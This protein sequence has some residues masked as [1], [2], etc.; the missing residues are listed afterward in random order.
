MSRLK[1]P[2]VHGALCRKYSDPEYA[3]F[4]E[5]HDK[6]GAHNTSADAIAMGLWKSR[7]QDLHGFEIKDFRSD[8]L[9]ELKNPAKAER[10][11]SYCDYW[12]L[13]TSTDQVAKLDEIPSKWGLMVLKGRNLH[14]V[15]AAP[16]LEAQPMSR[17]FLAALLRRGH[18]DVMSDD[19]VRAAIDKAREEGEKRAIDNNQ[20]E[21]R[22]ATRERD[23]YKRA[24]E[25]FEQASG[26]KIDRYDGAYL[27]QAVKFLREMNQNAREKKSLM[28]RIGHVRDFLVSQLKEV[29]RAEQGLEKAFAE[30]DKLEGQIAPSQ[31]DPADAA[32]G[33]E[34]RPDTR[35]ACGV[36]A[37]EVRQTP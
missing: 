17:Q 32:E 10:I 29:T 6:I 12:W 33:L 11:S 26:I 20:H 21:F 31:N 22:I 35:A 3:I 14:V 25:E 13:A 7:G 36:D 5:V 9:R 30:L 19:R 1:Q 4:F 18:E 15:K 24:I 16:R 2:G 28:A 8:W 23:N 34:K 37:S 27:G